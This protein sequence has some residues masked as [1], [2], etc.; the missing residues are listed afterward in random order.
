MMNLGDYNLI[1]KKKVLV[2]FDDMIEDMKS[3]K[4]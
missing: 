2:A 1:K 4:K 3:N